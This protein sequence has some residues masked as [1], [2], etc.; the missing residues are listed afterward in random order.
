MDKYR[1]LDESQLKLASAHVNLLMGAD[2]PRD[3]VPRAGARRPCKRWLNGAGLQAFC[4][5]LSQPH[6]TRRGVSQ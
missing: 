3:G 5:R 4:G 1:D 2:A 6:E